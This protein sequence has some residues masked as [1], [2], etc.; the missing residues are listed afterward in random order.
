MF[1]PSPKCLVAVPCLF[2]TSL[3]KQRRQICFNRVVLYYLPVSLWN[4]ERKTPQSQSQPNSGE[5]LSVLSSQVTSVIP[6]PVL[7]NN[8]RL[9]L[10]CKFYDTLEGRSHVTTQVSYLYRRLDQQRTWLKQ[11]ERVNARSCQLL[12]NMLSL[13]HSNVYILDV[14]QFKPKYLV[15][16]E[17]Y[18]L[19]RTY[20]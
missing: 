10:R 7:Q 15:I 13:I 9:C 11:T 1:H 4:Q 19:Y 17:Q 5:A 3:Q 14:I 16:L 8:L 20:M 18:C 2:S 6:V 12:S